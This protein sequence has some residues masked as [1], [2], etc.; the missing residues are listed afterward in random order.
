MEGEGREVREVEGEGEKGV[1]EGGG[2]GVKGRREVR[3]EWRVGGGE[4]EGR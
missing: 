3:V 4:G 2:G 1:N